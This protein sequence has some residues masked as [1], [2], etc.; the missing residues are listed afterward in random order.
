M[1]VVA[2]DSWMCEVKHLSNALIG[3]MDVLLLNWM[4]IVFLV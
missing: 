1:Y 2:I 3:W 4:D